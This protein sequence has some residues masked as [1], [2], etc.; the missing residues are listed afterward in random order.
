MK[1]TMALLAG[2][3][4]AAV[5]AAS[6]T[7]S[8]LVVR[9]PHVV[10][11][12]GA[13]TIV[14]HQDPGTYRTTVLAPAAYQLPGVRHVAAQIGT[15]TVNVSTFVGPLTFTGWIVGADPA[16]Y[17]NDHC[18]DF[19]ESHLAVWLMVLR[20]TNG[21][22]RT[23]IPIFV[24]AAPGGRTELTW[25]ASADADMTA[26]SVGVRFDHAFVSPYVAGAY[27]WQASFDNVDASSRSVL[28]ANASTAVVHVRHP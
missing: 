21:L 20:Q 2:A 5:L 10:R 27:A 12:A 26:T 16:G 28:G 13:T 3:V 15:A 9:A 6:A 25:C 22:A 18:A 23:E 4:G 17:V 1:R 11:A 19:T 14:T 7:A 24:D 8:T